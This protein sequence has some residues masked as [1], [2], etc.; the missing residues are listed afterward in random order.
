M[1]KKEIVI[2]SKYRVI[3]TYH[4]DN[5]IRYYRLEDNQDNTICESYNRDS[6]LLKASKYT[7]INNNTECLIASI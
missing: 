1:N 2:N 4:N 3:I 7:K 6:F 5:N